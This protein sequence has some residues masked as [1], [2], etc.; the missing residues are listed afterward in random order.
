MGVPYVNVL[1]SK[2]VCIQVNYMWNARSQFEWKSDKH[3]QAVCSCDAI[4]TPR[5]YTEIIVCKVVTVRPKLFWASQWLWGWRSA[6]QS[7]PHSGTSS[8]AGRRSHPGTW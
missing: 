7:I 3:N 5:P 6:F 2:R 8:R 1:I 4:E